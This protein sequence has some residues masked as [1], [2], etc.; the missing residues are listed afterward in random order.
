MP[1]Q[2][3]NFQVS[4]VA[5]EIVQ[6]SPA[7]KLVPVQ[8]YNGTGAVIYLGDASVTT[9]GA[10]I[11]NAI[12]IGGQLQVWLQANDELYAICATAPSLY[13]SIIFTG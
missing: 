8:I 4:T 7:S 10:T 2:H 5:R 6:L 12:A 9:S 3:R 1:L 13:G 11:G